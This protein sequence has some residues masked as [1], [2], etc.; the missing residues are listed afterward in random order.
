MANELVL[1]GGVWKMR[2]IVSA[3]EEASYDL[4]AQAAK[5]L[6]HGVLM[7]DT[8]TGFYYKNWKTDGPGIPVPVQ[9]FDDVTGYFSN[10]S[11]N[12]A[13]FTLDDDEDTD[14]DLSGRGWT[15]T[16]V[17]NGTVTKTAGNPAVISSDTTFFSRASVGFEKSSSTTPQKY[18]LLVKIRS[19]AKST[20]AVNYGPNLNFRLRTSDGN[21]HRL[22]CAFGN[23]NS[24]G[25]LGVLN[26]ASGGSVGVGD[27]VSF[28]SGWVLGIHDVTNAD[29]LTIVQDLSQ[30][31]IS[32]APRS[33][34]AALTLATASILAGA[35]S[36][37]TTSPSTGGT[38]EIQ[39]DEMH[40]LAMSA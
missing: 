31:K 15:I 36:G 25:K 38:A 22:Y 32:A 18:L 7:K 11:S 29:R 1:E 34:A 3:R 8:S 20:T 13:Y 19:Y 4:L 2:D 23:P 33:Y 6:E 26:Y 5:T 12:F 28:T 14:S 10:G 16:Q 9:Y 35:N 37:D 39:V 17:N 24:D 21:I 40:C 30:S 27:F